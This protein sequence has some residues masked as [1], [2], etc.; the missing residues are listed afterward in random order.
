VASALTC[1]FL[2]LRGRH[3]QVASTYIEAFDTLLSTYEELAE[4]LPLYTQYESY[5]HSSPYMYKALGYVYKDL[6]NFHLRVYKI[7]KSSSK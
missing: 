4:Y 7:M 6:L 2:L 3:S 5:F 1:V